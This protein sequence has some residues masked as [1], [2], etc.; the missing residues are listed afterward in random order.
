MNLDRRDFL[1]LAGAG[2]LGIALSGRSVWAQAP[3]AAEYVFALI[4]DPHLREDREDEPTGVEK[5]G[6][7]MAALEREQAAPQFAL[8]LGDIHPEK[9]DPLLPEIALPLYPIAGNHESVAH[10]EQLRGMF[11]DV[12]AGSDF[13][14]FTRGEDLFIG[15][16]TAIPGDHVGHLQSQYITPKIEQPKWLEDLLARRAEYRHVFLFGHIPPAPDALSSTMCLARNDALWLR[17]L[18]AEHRLTAMFFGHRHCQVEFEL[19]GVPVLGARSTN[20]NSKGEPAG[21]YLV[22]VTGGGYE[23]RFVPSVG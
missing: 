4:A 19:D 13:Y 18:A 22:S 14:S 17:D 20:W 5:F 7:A 1:Q 12:F 6:I 2:A 9:L 10:R 3:G 21:T 8:M 15:L 11:P 16:C 23:V